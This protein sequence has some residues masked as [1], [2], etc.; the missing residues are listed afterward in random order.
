VCRRRRRRRGGRDAAAVACHGVLVVVT[1]LPAA[2]RGCAHR[3]TVLAVGRVGE[4]CL[5]VAHGDEWVD[6]E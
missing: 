5:R 3:D 4:L 2:D 1:A 6:T